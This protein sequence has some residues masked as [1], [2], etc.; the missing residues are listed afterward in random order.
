MI[1]IENEGALFR[2]L[3]RS[4]PAEVWSRKE[5][6]FVPYTGTTPKPIEWGDEISGAEAISM[7]MAVTMPI[8]NTEAFARRYRSP[9]RG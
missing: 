6:K 7:M 1:Y 3:S 2:G 5:R 4:W 8:R 9:R